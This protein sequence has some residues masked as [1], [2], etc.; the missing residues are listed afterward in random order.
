MM[1]LLARLLEWITGKDQYG[2]QR[3]PGWQ[4]PECRKPTIW[5]KEIGYYGGD[6]RCKCNTCGASW[7]AEGPDG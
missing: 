5:T 4:C 7:V 2:Y 1:D 6:L 3:S